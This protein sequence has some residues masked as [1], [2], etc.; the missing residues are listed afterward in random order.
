MNDRSRFPILGGTI[1]VY[2]QF[3][4]HIGD[5]DVVSYFAV[6]RFGF[7]ANFRLKRLDGK[8]SAFDP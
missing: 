5:T 7:P 2:Q 8:E 4:F 1:L 3:P 6:P